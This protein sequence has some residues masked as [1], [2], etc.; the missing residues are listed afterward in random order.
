[1]AE[2]LHNGDTLT[3]AEHDS[4]TGRGDPQQ[5]FRIYRLCVCTR[6]GGDGHW[7]TAE[8][9]PA[10]Y[11]TKQHAEGSPFKGKVE[12]QKCTECRGEGKT[13]DL[14]ATAPDPQAVG[15]AL[16][17]LAREG[18]FEGCPVGVL[19]DGGAWLIK[20]WLPSTRNVADAAR[21]LAKSKGEK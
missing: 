11:A 10:L 1:M 5:R 4:V 8:G 3:T 15:V 13:L 19:E 9:D 2:A 17:S 21:V 14:V 18:E 20:P 12:R 6:C 7:F 16:I